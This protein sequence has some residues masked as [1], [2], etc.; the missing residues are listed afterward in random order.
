MSRKNRGASPAAPQAPQIEEQK[1]VTESQEPKN[2]ETKVEKEVLPFDMGGHKKF[3]KFKKQG[4][5]KHD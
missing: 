4:D 1:P 3:D 2:Q 5:L